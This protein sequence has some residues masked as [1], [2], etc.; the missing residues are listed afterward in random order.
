MPRVV[1]SAVRD[2]TIAQVREG[3]S[4]IRT[5]K[6]DEYDNPLAHCPVGWVSEDLCL[7]VI[8][9]KQHK[10]RAAAKKCAAKK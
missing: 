7:A 5:R 3:L 8:R 9:G 4:D 6:W 10:R 1:T 2:M